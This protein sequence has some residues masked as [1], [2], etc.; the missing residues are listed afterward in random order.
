MAMTRPKLTCLACEQPAVRTRIVVRLATGRQ[1]TTQIC[2][3]CG[4]VH[5][6]ENGHDY[7]TSTSPKSLGMA[8][9]CGTNKRRGR[10]FG[11]AQL[12]VAA[13]GR[14]GLRVLIY[15]VGRSKDNLHIATLAEVDRVA[16]GDIMKIRD[17]GEFV[18]ISQPAEERFDVVI[19]CE[20]VE[21]FVD[22]QPEF[23]KLL[24][25]VADDGIVVCSTNIR[26][27]LPLPRVHYIFGRGHVSYYSPEAL[28]AIARRLGARLD[29]RFPL[30]ATGGAGERK[31][32]VILSRSDEVMDRVS[33][34]FGSHEYAPSEP[35]DAY[36]RPKRAT[37]RNQP[38]LGRRAQRLWL[39][40]MS[41]RASS[42][43][44][45]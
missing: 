3:A 13:V 32:Y 38:R 5:L 12:G 34:Y 42:P 16:I 6:P 9:R 35:L 41:R 45:G 33:D 44:P 39:R 43:E 7:T 37:T 20:V 18:E 22:P 10:E 1:M 28:R 14:T 4:Y 27:A 21:H 31:R 17:D 23:A 40:T 26:D 19:A 36:R 2:G 30:A 25:F 15:G 11:M 24:T 29:F 8:P